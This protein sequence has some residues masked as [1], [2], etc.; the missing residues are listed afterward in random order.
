MWPFWRLAL[1]ALH[2]ANVSPADA[3]ASRQQTTF[4]PSALPGLSQ[5]EATL[6]SLHLGPDDILTVSPEVDARAESSAL[7]NAISSAPRPLSVV[8]LSDSPG[9]LE[10][11]RSDVE[12]VLRLTRE[13]QVDARD[14]G[15]TPPEIS[16]KPPKSSPQTDTTSRLQI[17][18]VHYQR[19]T[20]SI[21]TL[22]VYLLAVPHA[23]KFLYSGRAMARKHIP[24][25]NTFSVYFIV[26]NLLAPLFGEGLVHSI[27]CS[28][29]ANFAYRHAEGTHRLGMEAWFIVFEILCVCG[30]FANVSYRIGLG[31][32]H[33]VVGRA[34]VPIWVSVCLPVLYPLHMLLVSSVCDASFGIHNA[35]LILAALIKVVP[36]YFAQELVLA[37]SSLYIILSGTNR[38][39]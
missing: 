22:L 12:S 14:L 18:S 3:A 38:R 19:Y 1:L 4:W 21:P 35:Q 25:V 32:L 27:C 6:E 36:T 17:L 34:H 20:S 30:I 13:R 31:L 23:C 10:K 33:L 37:C 15:V 2:I 8:V 24:L 7:S 26:F 11:L 29:A 39:S 16:V 5:P 28:L 9:E